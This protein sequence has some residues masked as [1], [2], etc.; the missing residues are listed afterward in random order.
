[1]TSL[2]TEKGGPQ[3]NWSP[4]NS[5]W[6]QNINKQTRRI[7]SVFLAFGWDLL[8][9]VTKLY[10]YIFKIIVNY[11]A[12]K[13]KLPINCNQDLPLEYSRN[14]TLTEDQDRWCYCY[15]CC[16]VLA[17]LNSNRLLVHPKLDS[18]GW[19]SLVLYAF[20]YKIFT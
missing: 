5:R 17:R 19:G 16:S 8:E 14:R 7:P 18:V 3:Y 9:L 15:T 20:Y 12:I 2:S 13:S 1:M 4:S 10:C 11:K 6:R